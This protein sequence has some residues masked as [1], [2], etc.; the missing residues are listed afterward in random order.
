MFSRAVL[1]SEEEQSNAHQR[2]F[3]SLIP[4]P[5]KKTD[6][7]IV[8]GGTAT[9]GSVARLAA[10]EFKNGR[11]D[12]VIVAGGAPVANK[13]LYQAL[14]RFSPDALNE[15]PR[16]DFFNRL[17]EARYMREVL[18]QSNVCFDSIDIAGLDERHTDKV[19]ADVLK[20][21]FLESAGSVTIMAYGPYAERAR[22]TLRHQG[23]D[24][25]VVVIPVGFAGMEPDNWHEH[26]I[27]RA[28][29]LE[30]A[31][32]MDPKNKRGY[33]GQFC[34]ETDH[35]RERELIAT[36]PDMAR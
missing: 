36:L 16:I 23:F 32:N 31:R 4:V 6:V 34:A 8:M 22:A 25:P 5:D 24:K 28:Y 18:I 15:I 30:E 35:E 26:F 27:A 2:L 14:K 10:E 1:V 3:A 19:I 17:G 29:V 21:E 33:I 12:K 9:S 11:F 20:S 7:A 13:G